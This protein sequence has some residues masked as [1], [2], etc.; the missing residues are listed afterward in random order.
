MTDIKSMSLTEM[1]DY[2]KEAGGAGLPGQAG[3]SVAPSGST[4]F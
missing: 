2:F 1:T 3:L 4:V